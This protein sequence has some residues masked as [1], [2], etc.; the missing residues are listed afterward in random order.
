MNTRIWLL[1]MASVL[2]GVGHLRGGDKPPSLPDPG[3]DLP[4]DVDGDGNPDFVTGK[5]AYLGRGDGTFEDV[6]VFPT[7]DH[8]YAHRTAGADFNRDG[9]FDLAYLGSTHVSV[10][11]S[12]LA[13]L[14]PIQITLL[15]ASE[16]PEFTY[17]N[18]RVGDLNGDGYEDLL[19]NGRG[20]DFNGSLPCLV[21]VLIFTPAAK[22]LRG[23]ANF[24]G[25]TD[26][27]D[28]VAVLS[29]LFQGV[30][31]PELV[32]CLD[33]ADVDDTGAVNLS[34]VV[35]LLGHL[36]LGRPAPPAPS[37][38]SDFDPTVDINA[39]VRSPG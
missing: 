39:C 1:G 13:A 6:R 25:K 24:D 32:T 15:D 9:L 36:F 20:C 16:G 33:P 4:V 14:A 11:W 5:S 22:F 3:Y 7:F 17:T 10:R 27:A 28:A 21:T 23:D 2:A 18:L 29:H 12:F 26:I 8:Y 35:Y 37:G 30:T 34:D 19:V 31:S 38:A